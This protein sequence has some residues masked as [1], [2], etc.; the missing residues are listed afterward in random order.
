MAALASFVGTAAVR[1]EVSVAI[2]LVLNLP[3]VMPPISVVAGRG[4]G[5]MTARP[6]QTRGPRALVVERPGPCPLLKKIPSEPA[7]LM[8]WIG[9]KLASIKYG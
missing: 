7:I 2:S 1:L 3:L 5:E 4:P 6:G 9:K 8:N